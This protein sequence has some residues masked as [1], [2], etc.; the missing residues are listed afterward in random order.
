MDPSNGSCDLCR[1][2]DGRYDERET[3]PPPPPPAAFERFYATANMLSA[4]ILLPI[5]VAKGVHPTPGPLG[6]LYFSIALVVGLAAT[7]LTPRMRWLCVVL[8]LTSLALVLSGSALVDPL[9]TLI[10]PPM[11]ILQL[12]HRMVEFPPARIG[13]PVLLLITV[14][15]LLRR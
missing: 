5:C 6:Q 2:E 13:T 3:W 11:V 7:D 9:M 15:L 12:V 14:L 10:L 1:D 4:S 8:Y